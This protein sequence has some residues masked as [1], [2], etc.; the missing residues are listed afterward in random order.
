MP[1]VS[2][3]LSVKCCR[4]YRS[5]FQRY[6]QRDGRNS[7]FIGIF[8]NYQQK[9]TLRKFTMQISSTK[10]PTFSALVSLSLFVQKQFFS[11]LHSK[12]EATVALIFPHMALLKKWK[13]CVYGG[14]WFGLCEAA[15]RETHVWD[16]WEGVVM[17]YTWALRQ[18]HL[19]LFRHSKILTVFLP[20]KVPNCPP[21]V[22]LSLCVWSSLIILPQ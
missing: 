22:C 20:T 21:A 14:A 18:V 1:S 2:L 5:L 10:L 13:P 11:H 7:S 3:I 15:Q 8:T 9:S 4:I 19:L 6:F 17:S 12:A 16:A